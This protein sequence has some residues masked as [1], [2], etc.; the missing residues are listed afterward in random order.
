MSTLRLSTPRKW[1]RPSGC[2]TLRRGIG[3][4]PLNRLISRALLDVP[5]GGPKWMYTTRGLSRIRH[6]NAWPLSSAKL[7]LMMGAFTC[8]LTCASTPRDCPIP[9]FRMEAVKPPV[10]EKTSTARSCES[11]WLVVLS[12]I[13]AEKSSVQE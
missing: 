12:E 10:P 13:L 3:H 9:S 4:F 11:C 2:A 5:H 6:S 8:L 1:G 7:S